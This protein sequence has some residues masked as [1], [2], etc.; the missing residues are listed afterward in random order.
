MWDACGPAGAGSHFLLL[1]RVLAPT[2]WA[3]G[4]S[5]QPH[6][7]YSQPTAGPDLHLV[8]SQRRRW[9]LGAS[10]VMGTDTHWAVP[11]LP[12]PPQ[13]SG[14]ARGTSATS[15]A[16]QLSPSASSAR[17]HSVK[18]TTRGRWCPRHWKAD[19]AALNMTLCLPC[20]RSTGARSSVNWNRKIPEK[21]SKNRWLV[22]LLFFLFL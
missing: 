5:S 12:P 14:S 21:T 17:A 2:G 9:E 15:A 22:I 6:R 13:E 20:R 8:S 1:K 10:R 7:G 19:S 16:A 11:L 4:S 18:I 3:P